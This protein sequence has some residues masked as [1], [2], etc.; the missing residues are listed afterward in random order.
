MT[1]ARTPGAG[2]NATND[3]ARFVPQ[4]TLVVEDLDVL[5]VLAD[6]ESGPVDLSLR[7]PGAVVA[8][9]GGLLRQGEEVQSEMAERTVTEPSGR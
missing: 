8:Y 5:R 1:D 3:P 7:R 9:P 6:P 4:V 2:Q